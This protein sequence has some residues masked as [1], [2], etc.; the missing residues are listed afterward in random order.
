MVR[1]GS[2]RRKA[3]VGGAETPKGDGNS[4]SQTVR[5]SADARLRRELRARRAGCG[6]AETA[7]RYEAWPKIAAKL[8][9]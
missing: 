5:S 2:A 6:M 8:E 7:A 1:A 9:R 3:E 4:T